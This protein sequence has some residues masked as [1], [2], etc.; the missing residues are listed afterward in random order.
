MKLVSSDCLF[1]LC[2]CVCA[3]IGAVSDWRTRRIPNLLTGSSLVLGLLLHLA[4]GGWR[5]MG[6]AAAAGL[7]CGT[8]FFFFFVVGGMGGGDVKLMTA[9][10]CIAGFGS[11]AELFLSTVLVG[12]IFAVALA[13]LRGRLKRT[14][15]N[16]GALILH[17]GQFGL[18]E[19]PE[20]NLLNSE[21]LRLPYGI[22]I[23]AG[24][25]IT[26][27]SQNVLR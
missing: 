11:L 19:H 9:V 8:G 5:Q 4:F 14:I 17:H 13:L 1:L 24:C 6:L 16:V 20:L 15:S 21:T 3:S 2:A 10:G 22:A 25:W 27:A 23:A 18:A 7:V 12:G 26:L